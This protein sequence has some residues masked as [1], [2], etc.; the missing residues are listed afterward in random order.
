MNRVK[1]YLAVLLMAAIVLSLAGCG[2]TQP[3]QA[4]ESPLSEEPQPTAVPV[5]TTG[6]GSAMGYGGQITVVITLT[7]GVITDVEAEGANETAGIGS[8]AIERLPGDI[9]AANSVKVDGVS[10]ATMS[11]TGLINAAAQAYAAATGGENAIPA[12]KMAAGT[13][14]NEVWAF[15]VNEKMEVS[16]TVSEDRILSIEVGKNGE[17]EPIVQNAVDLLIP[18]MLDS[19]SVSIDA[20][21]GATGSSSGIKHGTTLAIEQA[22]QAAGTD[23]SAIAH[24]QQPSEKPGAGT[25]EVLEYDVLVIGMGGAGSAAAMSAAEAQAAAGREVSVLAIDKAGKYGG[26]SA[27]TSEMMAINPP[28]FMKENK[29]E[30]S[31]VQLGV[32]ERPLE[33]DRKDK[34]VYVEK[35]VMK[36]EWLKYVEGDAK[37]DMLDLMLDYSGETLDWL[38]FDHGFTFGKPQLG[39]EPSATYFCVYQY[40][41]SFMDNKHIIITYFDQMY[42]DFT[43]LGGK[44]LLETEAYDLIVDSAS[45][46]V[47]GAKARGADG[48]EYTINAKSVVLATGGYCGNGDMTTELLGEEYYPLKGKWN[49]VGMTQNDGKMIKAALN[50]GAGTYNI[51]TTP[52]VHIGGGRAIL[53]D[54]ETYEADIN[55]KKEIVALNDVP[56][57]MA[58]SSN[59]MAVSKQGRRFSA[60]SG[61]GFLE[62]WKGGPEFYAIWSEDQVQRVKNEGFSTV[63]TGAFIS[64]GGVPVGYPVKELDDVIAVA[65]EK[66]LCYKADTLEELASMLRIDAKALTDTVDVYNGYCQSGEDKDFHKDPQFLVPVGSGPYYAFLGAPYAYSTTGGLDVNTQFQVLQENGADP[67]DGLYA[68]GTDCLGVLLSDKKAYVTYGGCAQGWAFTSGKLA[69][70]SAAEN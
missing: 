46:T 37:E 52:I 63:T 27:V 45:N 24:F 41:G 28:R 57:I 9:I 33:D 62:P 12:V 26:T 13:Y 36:S 18:R 17:T 22:L 42:K 70:Q 66:G 21:T 3:P 60:E 23:T 6:E 30:V 7:D 54:F 49:Q 1:K 55:G 65:I 10:G 4:T 47:T 68:A 15:S 32:F 20:I 69:G 43:D 14:T 39:V 53:H 11:S 38:V 25:Q 48:T 8:L 31:K 16:V 56:M 67:I 44:Y 35:D 51:S 34:S 59:V 64:Q 50:I 40:N 61:L 58:I 19:Q 29:Y 2:N 5:V